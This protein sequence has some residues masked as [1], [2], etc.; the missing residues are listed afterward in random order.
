[1]KRPTTAPVIS[2]GALLLCGSWPLLEACSPISAQRHPSDAPAI[3]LARGARWSLLAIRPPYLSGPLFTLILKEHWLTGWVAGESAPAGA[4]R[5]QIEDDSASGYGPSGPVAIDFRWTDDSDSAEGL[6]NGRHIQLVLSSAGLRGTIADN[7]VL[8]DL[9]SP[10]VTPERRRSLGLP[11]PRRS[12][13][14]GTLEGTPSFRNSWCE[15]VLDERAANGA[16]VG[17]SICAGMPQP[18]RLEIPVAA[19]DWL[20]RPE[21]MTILT[22][23]LSAPPVPPSEGQAPVVDTG[24][25]VPGWP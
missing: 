5:V 1:M 11:P 18:T 15:Y 8:P 24:A 7:S 4:V 14:D 3:S 9:V 16:F 6:W 17:T 22:V 25:D 13:V 20:S 23:F 12:D 19:G 10:T 2:L 21:L